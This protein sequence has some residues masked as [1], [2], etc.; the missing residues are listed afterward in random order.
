MSK[1]YRIHNHPKLELLCAVPEGHVIIDEDLYRELVRKHQGVMP[2]PKDEIIA[3]YC[4]HRHTC[5]WQGY[6]FHQGLSWG[7]IP[8]ENDEW[9][10][11]HRKECG[12]RII[13]IYGKDVFTPRADKKPAVQDLG[14]AN[15]WGKTP[16]IVIGCKELK[17]V[18]PERKLRM[19]V[20][21]VQCDV[22][23]Y[24]YKYDSS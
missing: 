8:S 4:E 24:V 14:Y 16:D 22:C 5:N 3:H 15:G 7:N 10:I 2:Y 21:E 17:H 23:G 19:H 13:P 11:W 9:M 18:R 20:Y 1:T 6:H 12:G